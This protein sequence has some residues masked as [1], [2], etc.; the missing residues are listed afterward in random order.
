[1]LMAQRGRRRRRAER[2]AHERAMQTAL[3]ELAHLTR[4]AMLGELSGSLAHELNQPLAAVLGNAQA[5]IRFL[6][7]GKPDLGEMR[8]IFHDIADDAK[9]AGNIIHGMRA[10]FKKETRQELEPVDV[11]GVV[12]QVLLLL[13]S[14]CVARQAEVSF[15]PADPL[16]PALAGR[17]ELMQVLINL[18]LNGLDAMK[19]QTRPRRIWIETSRQEDER[20][21]ICV[22]D[23]GPGIAPEVRDKLFTPFVSTK[24]SGL[25][26]GL[27]ISRGIV[28]RF[29]GRLSVENIPDGGAAFL[30][31]VPPAPP[32]IAPLQPQATLAD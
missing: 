10:M 20:I 11:N 22:R 31:Q 19:D 23:S 32:S 4:V 14:E 29:G 9:R 6:A 3:D 7:G 30:V 27:A 26:M 18:V 25:G 17:V 16:P 13:H 28:E 1:L 21:A 12:Q 8:A 5:G 24:T 2:R 15:L